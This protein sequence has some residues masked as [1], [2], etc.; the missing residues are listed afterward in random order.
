MFCRYIY[1]LCLGHI[2]YQVKHKGVSGPVGVTLSE[3]WLV[4]T[5]YNT[6]GRR[7]EISVAEFYEGYEEK[8]RWDFCKRFRDLK[9]FLFYKFDVTNNCLLHFGSSNY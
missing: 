5:Y 7:Y 4:Y 3:N 2:V 6:K 1:I 9:A 8:N